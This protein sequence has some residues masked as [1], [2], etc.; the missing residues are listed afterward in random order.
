M[1]GITKDIASHLNVSL[2]EALKIQDVCD[3][4]YDPDYS[5]MSYR[6]LHRMYEEAQR[7]MVG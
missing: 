2:D 3:E 4:W 5:E 6:Q 1:N 7:E